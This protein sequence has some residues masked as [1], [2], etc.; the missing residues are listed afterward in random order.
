MADRV[1]RAKSTVLFY[2]P[3]M[4]N[5]VFHNG[6]KTYSIYCS[7]HYKAQEIDKILRFFLIMIII[8]IIII[9]QYFPFSQALFFNFRNGESA[10]GKKCALPQK[11][12]EWSTGI[13]LRTLVTLS[14]S[15]NIQQIP[16]PL[17]HQPSFWY[18]PPP[19]VCTPYWPKN[20]WKC[21]ATLYYILFV[22]IAWCH[23]YVYKI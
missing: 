17:P 10:G 2:L 21:W 6:K 16:P 11:S 15:P 8:I 3:K 20:D 22:L 13:L 12:W 18:A 14:W 19:S 7:F 9:W 5:L 4:K 23:I 1:W